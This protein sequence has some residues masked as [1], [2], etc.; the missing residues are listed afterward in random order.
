MIKIPASPDRPEMSFSQKALDA[1]F[2]RGNDRGGGFDPQ[3]VPDCMAREIS[4]GANDTEASVYLDG[5]DRVVLVGGVDTADEWAVAVSDE[6]LEAAYAAQRPNI[7][8][9]L[10]LPE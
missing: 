2:S 8:G 10:V 6:A 7:R 5:Q 4:R 1:L 3:H 9:E